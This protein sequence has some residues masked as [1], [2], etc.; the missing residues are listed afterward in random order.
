MLFY[1]KGSTFIHSLIIGLFLVIGPFSVRSQFYNGSQMTFGK[2]RVQYNDFQWTFYQFDRFD[3]YLYLNGKELALFTAQYAQE[4]LQEVEKRLE[5]NLDDKIQFIIFN[6]LSDMKQ[7]NLGLFNES[8]TYNT[9]GITRILDQKVILYF[10]GDHNHFKRQI[11][12]GITQVVLNQMLYGTSLTSQVKNSTLLFLPDWY[13]NGLLSY[14]TVDWNTDIDNRVRD[15]ILSG[16]YQKFNRLTGQDAAFAGHSIWKFV[17]D[18]YGPN[19]VTNIIYMAKISKNVESGFMFVLGVSFKTITREWINFYKDKYDLVAARDSLPENSSRLLRPKPDIVY[20]RL[21]ISSD[22]KSTAYSTNEAGQY[23]VYVKNLETGKRKRILKRGYCLDEETDYSYPLLA[24]HPSG[25]LLTI[26]TEEKGKTNLYFYTLSTGKFDKRFLFNFD[27]IIDFSYS[28]DGKNLVMSAVIKGQSDIFVFNIASSTYEQIT[29]DLYDDMEPRFIDHG[30]KI[31]FCSNRPNDSLR[32]HN[33]TGFYSP[34]SDRHDIFVFDYA[35]KKRLLRRITDSPLSDERQPMEYDKGHITYLSDENGVFNRYIA[36]FDSAISFVDTATHYR[37]FTTSFPVTNYARNI[38]EQ[39]VNFQAGKYGEVVFYKNRY[40][41]FVGETRPVTEGNYLKLSNTAYMANIL[42]DEKRQQSDSLILLKKNYQ[43]RKKRFVNVKENE[44]DNPV[45]STRKVSGNKIDINNYVFEKQA[46][47]RIAIRDSLNNKPVISTIENKSGVPAFIVPKRQNYVVEYTMNQITSQADFAYLNSTYQPFTGGT[48]PIFLNPGFNVLL[49]VG[50]SDLME[51]YRITGGVRLSLNL[52]N[53]EYLLS[54]TNLKNR[55]DKEITFHRQVVENTEESPTYNIIRTTSHELFYMLAW[56]FSEVLTLRGIGSVRNDRSVYLS[57]DEQSLRQ[58]NTS[59]NWASL[60]GELV[61]DATRNLGLNLM[62]G[63]RY[64][65]FAE[66]YQQVTEQTKSL[67]VLGF[68]IRNYQRI[69]RTLIWANRF[70]TSTSFGNNRLI[71]Y[72]GG[73]DNWFNPR[74]NQDV[75]VSTNQDYAYQTLATNMR[76]FTQ[77]IRNGSS[78]AVLNS[79]FR[80]PVFRYFANRPIKS[81]FINNFQIIAFGD[82]GTAW[83]GPSP[84]SK[85]NSLYT[86]VV[87]QGPITVTIDNQVEPIVGGYGF[88]LRTRFLGYFLRADWAWGVEDMKVGKGL[89]YLSLSL[90][91]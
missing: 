61:Y 76:G 2:N 65:F 28:P 49:K 26:I 31:I 7:S 63:T 42:Q 52:A 38:I 46:F 70:A 80:L 12:E 57:I 13:L 1:T 90:D 25:K 66:Y 91:F 56:P 75:P 68:D 71:Y 62:F 74:F 16:R 79:E 53:N 88:G 44:L 9:G 8:E 35:G 24:W 41:L 58:P 82:I 39:D 20:N 19:V 83:N 73:V 30:K 34:M 33:N 32:P 22:G 59:K 6:S 81:D 47:I 87:Q 14:L 17:A 51:N 23:R 84:Y 60:K 55:L 77:N 43:S 54:F 5:T 45:D 11:R 10:D 48:S 40:Q 18:K 15:G 64:K 85:E 37:Y 50:L 69:H 36:R 27:K 21:K 3:T 29:N 67:Y 78:F 72:M 86:R 89:F 4:Q